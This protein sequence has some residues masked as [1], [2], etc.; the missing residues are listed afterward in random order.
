MTNKISP[1]P[2]FLI[3]KYKKW[4]SSEYVKNETKLRNLVGK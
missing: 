1:L 2:K 4:K 3:D